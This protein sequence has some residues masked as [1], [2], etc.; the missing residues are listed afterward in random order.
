MQEANPSHDLNL[1]TFLTHLS[2]YVIC[3]VEVTSYGAKLC[4]ANSSVLVETSLVRFFRYYSLFVLVES[5]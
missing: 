4:L 5:A 2:V 3:T 1:S